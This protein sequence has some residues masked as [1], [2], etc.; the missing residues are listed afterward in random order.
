MDS[1]TKS[2]P[3][4]MQFSPLLKNTD[5]MP[6]SKQAD[7]LTHKS[8]REAK[9]STKNLKLNELTMRTAL[10]MSQSAKMMS[11]DFPPSSKDTFLRLLTAQ[12]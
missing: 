10:S 11:G 4:A 8:S 9:L 2:R 1:S 7:R 5:P 6:W 3:A 12:L